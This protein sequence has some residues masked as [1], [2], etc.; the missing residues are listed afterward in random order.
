MACKLLQDPGVKREIGKHRARRLK[1]WEEEVQMV[2]LDTLNCAKRTIHDFI[3][4]NGNWIP[5]EQL[6]PEVAACIQGF[7]IVV[8]KQGHEHRVPIWT[9]KQKAQDILYKLVGLYAPEKHINANTS[10]DISDLYGMPQGALDDDVIEDPKLE[11]K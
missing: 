8:D 5:L 1:E 4:K 3:D 9:D 7:D 2:K 6:P 11:E 10:F